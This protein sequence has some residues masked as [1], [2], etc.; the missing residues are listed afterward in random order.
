MSAGV[1]AVGYATGAP[2]VTPFVHEYAHA[3]PMQLAV[4]PALVGH[5][6]QLVPHEAGLVLLRHLPAHKWK[7]E[8]QVMPH[9]PW[10]HVTLP[11]GS[12]AHGVQLEPHESAL[13]FA[14]HVPAQS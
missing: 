3:P 13:S 6:V 14:L 7:P 12:A 8:L 1:Y 4:A 10:L 9:C 2:S 5:G 11:F